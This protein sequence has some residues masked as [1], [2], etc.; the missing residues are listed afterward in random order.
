MRVLFAGL[1]PPRDVKGWIRAVLSSERHPVLQVIRYGLAGVAA[2]AAN[3][4]F[5]ALAEQ[6]L[7]P[8]PS[9]GAVETPAFPGRLSEL[10]RWLGELGG[11]PRVLNYIRCNVVAFFMANGVAYL[12]NFKWVF[13]GGR[14]SRR[15]EVFLFFLV[16]MIS[17]VVGTALASALVGGFGVNEYLAK[18]GDVLAAVAINFVCRKFLIFQS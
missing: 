6:T 5:F 10:G 15:V 14:H 3:L 8:V 7:F 4:L 1:P 18:I 16:S 13:Q 2:M 12:L 9:A 11:D 17:F